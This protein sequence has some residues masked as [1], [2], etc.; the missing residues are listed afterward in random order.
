[1]KMQFVCFSVALA[2][3]VTFGSCNKDDMA[4]SLVGNKAN[5]SQQSSL[6]KAPG[7]VKWYIESTDKCVD[8]TKKTCLNTV[9]IYSPKFAA[10]DAAVM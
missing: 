1:M 9:F 8:A 5:S 3:A 10:L 4:S 2:A 7:S 6:Q